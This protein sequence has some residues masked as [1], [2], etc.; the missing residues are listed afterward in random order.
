MA[1]DHD[2]LTDFAPVIRSLGVGQM[3]KSIIGNEIT[4]TDLG[5]FNAFP[6]I[7]TPS[8]RGQ[9]ALEHEGM[10][11]KRLFDAARAGGDKVLQVNHPRAGKLGYFDQ[12]KLSPETAT[13]PDKD[14]VLGF[15]AIEVFNGKKV[16]DAQR[17][18]KDWYNFLNLGHRFTATG[19][20]D[21]HAVVAQEAGYPR[22]FIASKTD[23]PGDIQDKDIIRAIKVERNIVV[24]NG[25]FVAFTVN[26][27]PIGSV[28]TDTDG[29]VTL[30]VV[31]QAP[32]WVDVSEIEVIGNGRSL[33]TIGVGRIG[34]AMKTQRTLNV[35]L[36][37]DTW[38]V[39]IARGEES[40]APVVPSRGKGPAVTPFAFTNPIWVDTN[41]NG[42]FDPP[43]L[44]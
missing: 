9:G 26:G 23:A 42:K 21:T 33:Q 34:A 44:N 20:S 15:D 11:P 30:N 4:T 2:Y 38:F 22:N 27:K 29:K 7:P 14:F 28:V 16:S 39:V 18:L 43:G 5:H 32:S 8:R 17:V 40:L 12:L 24:T 1:S 31:V 10:T 35:P 13:S 41:G 36:T 25:P 37:R 3:L 19:N 6:L